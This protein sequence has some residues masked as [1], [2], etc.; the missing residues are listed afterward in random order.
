MST[1]FG[2]LRA[3]C[4]RAIRTGSWS[5]PRPVNNRSQLAMPASGGIFPRSF[6]TAAIL[7][8][9]LGTAAGG[10]LERLKLI[11]SQIEPVPWAGLDGWATDDHAAAFAAFR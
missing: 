11:D 2:R 1:T 10:D 7:A 9:L 6:A 3:T 8:A 5:R 4:P